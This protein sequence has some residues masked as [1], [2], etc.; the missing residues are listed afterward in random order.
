MKSNPSRPSAG[1]DGPFFLNRSITSSSQGFVLPGILCLII[2]LLSS[3]S[4]ARDRDRPQWLKQSPSDHKLD[5]SLLERA[6]E[7]ARELAPLNSLIVARDKTIVAEQ[8]YRGME[9]NGRANIKSASK[10]LISALVGIALK[11]GD[12]EGLDQTIGPFFPEILEGQPKKQAITLRNLLL[13]RSGLESTSFENYGT[14][15]T[16]D[17]WIR[18]ALNQPLLDPPG[19]ETR[20][21]TGN[22]HIL[23][24]ILSKATGRDLLAYAREH[25]FDPIGVEVKGWQTDPQGYRFGGNNLSLTPRG[26][27]RFGQLYLN[28]GRWQGQQ[29]VPEIWVEAST[30]QYV[31]DTYHGYPYG[32]FWWTTTYHN[33]R[34]I[35][36]WGHG[37]QYTFIVPD[38]DLVVA[39]TSGLQNLPENEDYHTER[40][41]GLL[42]D[43]LI[44]AAQ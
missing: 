16:S 15:V 26:L 10:S 37:G 17:N 4:Y 27:L 13:M 30:K 11:R 36:A 28:K 3:P 1:P 33:H 35:F 34:V 39:V 23:A 6:F 14:W 22:S 24:V 29:I 19:T 18:H 41:H 43:Y 25:L 40:I 31:H 38:L 2:L 7:R 42:R 12:L 32:Y 9:P 8:Y 21:S 20:Y 5:R 44:P